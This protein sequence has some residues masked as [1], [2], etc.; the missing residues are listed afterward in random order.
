MLSSSTK[1]FFGIIFAL[2]LSSGLNDLF[3]QNCTVNAGIF[4]EWCETDDIQLFGNAQGLVSSSSIQWQQ[5]GGP[6]VI[7]DNPGSLVSPIT[8]AQAGNLYQFRLIARCRDGSRV[9]DDV[10]YQELSNPFGQILWY[11]LPVQAGF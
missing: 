7:I 10:T 9:F 3:A 1:L 6:T 8:G 5:I 4:R 2:C 11:F